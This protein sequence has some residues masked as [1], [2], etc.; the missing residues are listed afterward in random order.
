MDRQGA[1]D[2]E[3]FGGI[4][5]VLRHRGDLDRGGLDRCCLSI[6]R[7]LSLVHTYLVSL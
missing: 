4:V 5:G 1:R 3:A 2:W 6:T 7:S